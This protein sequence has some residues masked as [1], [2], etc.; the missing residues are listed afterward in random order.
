M[1]SNA[2]PAPSILQ[3]ALIP[4]ELIATMKQ[5]GT[6]KIMRRIIVHNE[7]SFNDSNL[8]K[9]KKALEAIFNAWQQNFKAH[10]ITIKQLD[11]SEQG[12]KYIQSTVTYLI[13]GDDTPHTLL[14]N[15]GL[16]AE[17]LE[18]DLKPMRLPPRFNKKPALPYVPFGAHYTRLLA[19]WPACIPGIN[20]LWC[21]I[22]APLL[23]VWRWRQ[24]ENLSLAVFH[25]KERQQLE[26]DLSR[27]QKLS[28]P[29]RFQGFLTALEEGRQIVENHSK[30]GLDD[31]QRAKQ[32]ELKSSLDYTLKI[33]HQLAALLQKGSDF[34]A[35]AKSCATTIIDGF[36]TATKETVVATIPMGYQHEGNYYP[37]LITF[38]RN[39]EGQLCLQK[40]STDNQSRENQS[41]YQVFY[42]FTSMQNETLEKLLKDLWLLQKDAVSP[43]KNLKEELRQVKIAKSYNFHHSTEPKKTETTPIP[44]HDAIDQ[45]ILTR[46]GTFHETIPVPEADR[47]L[48]KE[49]ELKI[50][51][52]SQ[53]PSH[54]V[55]KDPWS[56]ISHWMKTYYTDAPMADKFALMLDVVSNHLET[57]FKKFDRFPLTE[58]QRLLQFIKSE[59]D[60][61]Q[62][63]MEKQFSGQKV[64]Q[65]L[66]K[67]H[68]GFR[69]LAERITSLETQLNVL[70]NEQLQ[71]A[72]EANQIAFTAPA[73]T[74]MQLSLT[75]SPSKDSVSKTV[76]APDY[77]YQQ[78]EH[79]QALAKVLHSNNPLTAKQLLDTLSAAIEKT[80]SQGDWRQTRLLATQVLTLLPVP[81]LSREK[82]IWDVISPEHLDSWGQQ[83]SA[84]SQCLW[85]AKLLLGEKNL[86]PNELISI[87]NGLAILVKIAREKSKVIKQKYGLSDLPT[88]PDQLKEAIKQL[89]E[90]CLNK[91]LTFAEAA[92]LLFD[93]FHADFTLI[94]EFLANES[95][96]PSLDPEQDLK[97]VQIQHY[98]SS[99]DPGVQFYLS[100]N[101]R[102]ATLQFGRWNEDWIKP[103]EN[104]SDSNLDDQGRY[105]ISLQL[106]FAGK[107]SADVV[108][109]FFSAMARPPIDQKPSKDQMLFP[110]SLIDLRR[111]TVM[112]RCLFSPK[113]TL[114]LGFSSIGGLFAGTIIIS[115]ANTKSTLLGGT[116]DQIEE[117]NRQLI[118]M[119]KW[120]RLTKMKRLEIGVLSLFKLDFAAVRVTPKDSKIDVEGLFYDMPTDFGKHDDNPNIHK[121][122][123]G[124]VPA[125]LYDTPIG[126]SYHGEL[127]ALSRARLTEAG[128]PIDQY[129]LST[130][131]VWG[132]ET[133]DEIYYSSFSTVMES[134]DL[135]SQRRYLSDQE[136][137]QRL[138]EMSLFKFS[139]MQRQL[140][141]DAVSCASRSEKMQR[142]IESALESGQEC[143]A[144]FLMHVGSRI[145]LFARQTQLPA[146]EVYTDYYRS[147][148][149]KKM[150]P[151]RNQSM[152]K[153]NAEALALIQKNFPH[154]HSIFT[155]KERSF[156]GR[157]IFTR[158]LSDVSKGRLH[159]LIATFLLDSFWLDCQ[160]GFPQISPQYLGQLL[161][162]YSIL[163]NSGNESGMPFLQTQALNW[164][165]FVAIPHYA[166]HTTAQER[167][168]ALD[169]FY[170]L[171][172]RT[173]PPHGPWEQSKT[174]PL[175][176][177]KG[178]QCTLNLPTGLISDTIN[179][180]AGPSV[181]LPFE[182]INSEVYQK[183][184]G[185]AQF[186]AQ[187]TP[188][189]ISGEFIYAIELPNGNQ[190]RI[191][192]SKDF[193]LIFQK[194]DAKSTGGHAG[195]YQFHLVYGQNLANAESM[196][197]KRGVWKSA[198]GKKGVLFLKTN[199]NYKLDELLLIDFN[200]Q[201]QVA[202]AR[203]LPDAKGK[204]QIVCQDAQGTLT[205]WLSCVDH[206]QLLFL[207]NAQA[208]CPTEIRILDRR[209]TLQK[210]P[211]HK[212]WSINSGKYDGFNWIVNFSD[213]NPSISNT[214]RGL[215][216]ALGPTLFQGILPLGNGKEERLLIWPYFLK[217]NTPLD[218][219]GKRL[220]EFDRNGGS[221]SPLLEVVINAEGSICA[222]CTS[223]LY[224]AYLFQSKGQF[225]HAYAYLQR[226]VEARLTTPEEKALFDEIAQ[227][228]TMI[229]Q[230]SLRQLAFKLKAELAISTIRRQQ[231]HALVYNPQKPEDVSK[232]FQRVTRLTSLYDAYKMKYDK[233]NQQSRV[234]HEM[235]LELT[236][237]EEN[238]FSQVRAESLRF[239][240]EAPSLDR[241]AGPTM[242]PSTKAP[243]DIPP[244]FD[245]HL[246]VFMAKPA[247]IP[248]EALEDI[249]TITPD[250]V[251]K[252]FWYYCSQIKSK[253]VKLKDLNKLSI[254]QTKHTQIYGEGEKELEVSVHFA[255]QLLVSLA[256]IIE[257][258]EA[259]QD[260]LNKIPSSIDEL[261]KLY[262][263]KDSLPTDEKQLGSNCLTKMYYFIKQTNGMDNLDKAT[264]A[265]YTAIGT[266]IHSFLYSHSRDDISA[267]KAQPSEPITSL[268]ILHKQIEDNVSKLS[269][270]EQT[271]VKQLI[272]KL[273][274][275]YNAVNQPLTLF[276][277]IETLTKY[278]WNIIETRRLDTLVNRIEHLKASLVKSTPK[279]EFSNT[280][281]RLSPPLEQLDISLFGKVYSPDQLQEIK[282]ELE[283]RVEKDLKALF[284]AGP[285][286]ATMEKRE[287]HELQKGLKLAQETLLAE[288]KA[289]HTLR[290]DQLKH[291]EDM[292]SSRI[293]KLQTLTSEG[294][295]ILLEC[296]KSPQA[297]KALN[298]MMEDVAIHGEAAV[299]EK[300]LECY[301]KGKW[302]RN[303]SNSLKYDQIASVIT[304]FLFYMTELQQLQKAQVRAQKLTLL[305]ENSQEFRDHANAVFHLIEAGSNHGRY[306]HQGNLR[307]PR[308]H[309]KYLVAE[310]RS[311]K[312]LKAEQIEAITQIADNP[313][314]LKQ[315]RMG[316]GKTTIIFPIVIQLL[317]EQGVLPVGLITQELLQT[318]S[319]D[320]DSNTRTFFRQA[321]MRFHFD[322]NTS[323]N[324]VCLAEQYY[325]LLQCR[326][327]QGYVINTVESI[328]SI[329]NKL[330]RLAA[331]VEELIKQGNK[332][333][334][335]FQLNLQIAWLTEIDAL[336]SGD[337]S[338]G[339]PVVL[340]GDEGDAIFDVR[341]EVNNAL[342]FRNINGVI[343]DT[344]DYLMQ[345]IM[346]SES[347]SKYADE[348]ALN[349]EERN[350]LCTLKKALIANT[351]VA[352]ADGPIVTQAIR[353][354]AK[355]ALTR[356]IR[357][358][359]DIK[360]DVEEWTN[361]VTGV[362]N[363]SL[364]LPSKLDQRG[365]ISAIKC[366]LS[367]IMPN[368]MRV[369]LGTNMG[370]KDSNGTVIVPMT[371]SEERLNTE[372]GDEYDKA[373]AHYLHYIV[374]AP[375]ETFLENGIYKLAEIDLDSYTAIVKE[376]HEAA[377]KNDELRN[378]DPR[379]KV[380]SFLQSPEAWKYRLI[381][382]R[383]L[384]IAE[385]MLQV[386]EKEIPYNVQYAAINRSCGVISGTMAPA[387]L[388]RGLDRSLCSEGTENVT[389][390]TYLRCTHG[391]QQK[392]VVVQDN[393]V[394]QSLT[395]AVKDQSVKSVINQGVDMGSLSTFQII[396]KLRFAGPNRQYIFVNPSH[397]DNPYMEAKKEYL[398]N[399]KEE[400]PRVFEPDLVDPAIALFYFGPADTRG[401][402]FVMPAGLHILL[403]G[404]T[405][406]QAPF[407]QA[408][409]RPRDLGISHLL[410]C[411]VLESVLG[412]INERLKQDKQ[413]TVTAQTLTL[414]HLFN[415]FKHMTLQE[416]QFLNF[417][418]MA[419]HIQGYVYTE[420]RKIIYQNRPYDK[421]YWEP[422]NQLMCC[423]TQ[424]NN[425]LFA[426]CLENNLMIQQKDTDFEENLH[427][428]IQIDTSTK[429]KNL[430]QHQIDLLKKI[431]K[432]TEIKIRS[433]KGPFSQSF[434]I[435]ARAEMIMKDLDLLIKQ[436]EQAQEAWDIQN[437]DLPE[438]VLSTTSLNENSMV[439]QQQQQ[440]Q[441]QE[442]DDSTLIKKGENSSYHYREPD[443][444]CIFNRD[445]KEMTPSGYMHNLSHLNDIF[446]TPFSSAG[447]LDMQQI[448]MSDAYVELNNRAGSNGAPLAH[449]ALFKSPLPEDKENPYYIC[450]ISKLDTQRLVLK[451]HQFLV[452]IYSLEGSTKEE[453][454][455]S[456]GLMPFMSTDETADFEDPKLFQT[457]AVTRLLMGYTKFTKQQTEVLQ[458]WLRMDKRNAFDKRVF[459]EKAPN[460]VLIDGLQQK[461]YFNLAATITELLE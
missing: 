367:R 86:W 273:K 276:Q 112:T 33:G 249:V 212:T 227:H 263:F 438:T 280:H 62:Q 54:I 305:D 308:F 449:L 332:P 376:A 278:Q 448:Y 346:N 93:H 323:T 284:V 69:A 304:P 324:V 286:A 44:A 123:I 68:L 71:L 180:L 70:S 166:A 255:R 331:Q 96:L 281:I 425:I 195:W 237:E 229:S 235:E 85:E 55:G 213:T 189:A 220:L 296:A 390:E 397:S 219:H 435:K 32:Q 410:Q 344:T 317:A 261:K 260:Q 434:N 66:L 414:G 184:F 117:K 152:A 75:E 150:D 231:T 274:Y 307:D 84:I 447:L 375:S 146:S 408:A 271:Y 345:S 89:R 288:A 139:V 158:I 417:K 453:R 176:Y 309:R 208:N 428:T 257:N 65:N 337:K 415:D 78:Q 361:F 444:S 177:S 209:L 42:T 443:Y 49:E 118:H 347:E 247:E 258:P 191:E 207:K 343:L 187:S 217:D 175:I 326:Q 294:R 433:L 256:A 194:L 148:T 4:T 193:C 34:S 340:L 310:Y 64:F 188:G 174:E 6:G 161:H 356:L 244:S 2:N 200:T 371:N 386:A 45:I 303:A 362:K 133:N 250:N 452:G 450:I 320:L 298:K 137:Y 99:G 223:F 245:I 104:A 91:K 135:L 353:A 18:I 285:N 7:Q 190:I 266:I 401:R 400:N 289:L 429:V 125:Q 121:P 19:T 48:K 238:E 396:K 145:R 202:S 15:P 13:E 79:L 29:D 383:K 442:V 185:G 51:K 225:K 232:F 164:M 234:I 404:P 36:N 240:F 100:K 458:T 28:G 105:L 243:S 426:T 113:N 46:G 430:Y 31:I 181:P 1:N 409:F 154:Y 95:H 134:L 203:T 315:L 370:P 126:K 74:Q 111:Q 378:L 60:S 72:S 130:L 381:M 21:L 253:K 63:T 349:P 291:F 221:N 293:T 37:L 351:Y 149:S 292:L 9:Y 427:P 437:E 440:Q 420:L 58:K 30:E 302:T 379:A 12:E 228:L 350:S 115:E 206:S 171:F 122:S 272:E 431:K 335:I 321:A 368:F 35:L 436:I 391:T 106:L 216:R 372:Y 83:I 102:K 418:T 279:I 336:F 20:I 127:N 395:I 339:F 204:T 156:E 165:E 359:A 416:L 388:P 47:K 314:L 210:N 197:Q 153:D 393:N 316:K 352:L 412:R 405:T 82:N 242:L 140:R 120:Q 73:T 17:G 338:L 366:I 40:F 186:K 341:R 322:V 236:P 407:V 14:F 38:F 241:I 199:Q 103:K 131:N 461:H 325:R 441:Q 80:A 364:I 311:E 387:S 141:Y 182:L 248:A 16:I 358:E 264:S 275:R 218:P 119:H 192:W 5:S 422:S 24:P 457:C 318:H 23:A 155:V 403:V 43:K 92:E 110:T 411:W 312:I 94:N 222:S 205:Q 392:V 157:E 114:Y 455:N 369:S 360:Y 56:L 168:V 424:V 211:P 252:Y 413:A 380:L 173:N 269:P 384:V 167:T 374:R 460:K 159:K 419:I 355:L 319:E 59:V 108:K 233:L 27:L 101:D 254:A 8:G 26:N 246:L 267:N 328:A 262:K 402:N 399:P 170:T 398:W 354:L 265:I 67:T 421:K 382:L 201:G 394:L 451:P 313:T 136:E 132:L 109:N 226:A 300:I 53:L 306:L 251:L 129:L 432:E 88:N 97:L 179:K 198:D 196:I 385:G 290:K 327:E 143:A 334:E 160:E 214:A 144:A 287:N 423:E 183:V 215:F 116:P 454:A 329:A 277:L 348:N 138:F 268:A 299:I 163:K 445:R 365:K 342:G 459:P 151:S 169:T 333:L 124:K 81:S 128:N 377:E 22:I 456:T 301:Q 61:L 330:S 162:A 142:N 178:K 389:A 57:L 282:K 87:L 230:K 446:N 50:K 25:E 406:K 77:V 10:S 439:Q 11:I 39:A 90:N 41:A 98:L 52:E 172:F 239:L 373:V 297:P 76:T 224:L 283:K 295:A 363:A 3:K 107:P 357:Q 270:E 147:A 259:K